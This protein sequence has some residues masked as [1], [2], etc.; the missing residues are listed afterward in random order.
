M[1]EVPQTLA[2]EAAEEEVDQEDTLEKEAS[3]QAAAEVPITEA[4]EPLPPHA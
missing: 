2:Q 1:E 3:I 4:L